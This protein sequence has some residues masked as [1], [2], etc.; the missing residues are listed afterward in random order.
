MRQHL[1]ILTFLLGLLLLGTSSAQEWKVLEPQF[2]IIGLPS[3]SVLVRLSGPTKVSDATLRFSD[4]EVTLTETE[5]GVYQ[6]EFRL[7]VRG[8][9][10]LN[11]ES[12]NLPTR[13]LL[14]E[15][16]VE[17]APRQLYAPREL[18]TRQGPHADYDRLTPLYAGQTVVVEASRGSWYRCRGSQTWVD[19][20]SLEKDAVKRSPVTPNRLRRVM[21]E[22]D[23]NGDALLVLKVD[24]CPEV[25]VEALGNTLKVTLYDTYQTNFDLTRPTTTANFLGP[26]TLSPQAFPLATVLHIST[27]HLHGY[28]IEPDPDEKTLRIRVRKP[29]GSRFQDLKITVDAGH[30]GPK[31]LGTVGH[32]GLAEKELNLRVAKALAQKLRDLGAEVTMTRV[33]DSDVASFQ[34]SDSSELQ[35]R[36]D[37]S[38]AAGAQLFLSVHHNARADI[39]EGK[40]SHGTDIYWFHPQSE[41]LARALT[42][43][44]ADAVGETS[45]SF[46]WRSFHVIRQT[47]SP[48]VLLEFQYLS[49]PELER[50][51]LSKPDYP[52]KAAQGV[53]EGLRRY[54]EL[55]P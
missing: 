37:K 44:I 36:I 27:T 47:H 21:V 38:V 2:P 30:G 8:T 45:R 28:Q 33:T 29:H 12:S 54:L 42:D 7:P 5:E 23:L 49:N 24:R 1:K 51:V 40:I 20:S 53:V 46:R 48:A 9:A 35:S 34:G 26:I 19:G 25:Q 10:P 55:F 15:L 3:E 22:E 13:K 17:H 4:S 52:D 18:V 11:L 16:L 43:P 31:D 39:T 32:L 50:H 41:A 14:G 6:A